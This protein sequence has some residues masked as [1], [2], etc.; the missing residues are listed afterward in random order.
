MK[1]E[2]LEDDKFSSWFMET[3]FFLGGQLSML[4]VPTSFFFL[5]SIACFQKEYSLKIR[6][7]FLGLKTLAFESVSPF[8]ESNEIESYGL[9]K[10][11]RREVEKLSSLFNKDQKQHMFVEDSQV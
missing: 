4:K 7:P 1:A 6:V 2:E 11:G 5:G 8:G 10:V 3:G 9:Y